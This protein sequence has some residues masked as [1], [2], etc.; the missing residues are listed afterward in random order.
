M[1]K[2]YSRHPTMF[3][4]FINKI[5]YQSFT[6]HPA[7]IPGPNTKTVIIFIMLALMIMVQTNTGNIYKNG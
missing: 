4:T 3:K 1:L 6:K 5:A 2:Q 7:L